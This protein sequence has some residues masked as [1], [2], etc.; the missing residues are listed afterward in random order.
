M[1]FFIK[2]FASHHTKMISLYILPEE[3]FSKKA[4]GA[5]SKVA[6]IETCRRLDDDTTMRQNNND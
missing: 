3:F 5:L 6:N 2:I 4:M 1:T